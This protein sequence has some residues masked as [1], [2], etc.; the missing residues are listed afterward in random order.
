M[1]LTL[2]Y[3][4]FSSFCR[5]VLI[6]LYECEAEVDPIIVDFGDEASRQ[7]FLAIWPLGKFPV[8]RD[9][10]TGETMPESTI[11]IEYLADRFP[12]AALIP[13]DAAAARNVRLWDRIFDHYVMHPMQRIVADRLRPK[14]SRDPIGVEQARAQLRSA[15]AYLDRE[16]AG[17]NWAAGDGFSMADC[18][19]Q[20][21]LLFARM[22]EPWDKLPALDAY[23]A[24]LQAR[25][26]VK[27]SDTQAAPYEQFFPQE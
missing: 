9:E 20:P 14:G 16:L 25:P 1:A 13:A 26:S 7:A 8:L 6:A 27:R 19:A 18:A 22:V 5:K 2:W 3:H 4:P 21:S 15:Y 24:R 10:A 17:R 12:T 23:V 11:I